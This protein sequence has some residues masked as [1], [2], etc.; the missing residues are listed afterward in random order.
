MSLICHDSTTL[1]SHFTTKCLLTCLVSSSLLV[2]PS[3]ALI[4]VW[5]INFHFSSPINLLSLFLSSNGS[6]VLNITE[7]KLN[8]NFLSQLSDWLLSISSLIVNRTENQYLSHS[9]TWMGSN[10]KWWRKIVHLKLLNSEY[11]FHLFLSHLSNQLSRKFEWWTL[12]QIS[13]HR[14]TAFQLDT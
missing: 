1:T 9:S 13:L 7:K 11:F 4:H 12:D 8:S 10:L 2:P 3:H 6:E 14:E 5:V